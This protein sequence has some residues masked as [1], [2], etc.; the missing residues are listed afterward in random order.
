MGTS[1]LSEER[2]KSLMNPVKDIL[3][4]EDHSG[5]EF[6]KKKSLLNVVRHIQEQEA[7]SVS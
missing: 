5:N 7:H 3:E 2:K 6:I 1:L 4:C